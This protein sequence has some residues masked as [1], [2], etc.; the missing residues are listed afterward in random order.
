M[1]VC[2]SSCLC[3]PACNARTPYNTAL[4]GLSG[5]IAFFPRYLI[6]G[7]IFGKKK[8]LN[9]NACFYSVLKLSSETF[10]ILRRIQ[11]DIV[12]NVAYIGLYVKYQLFMSDIN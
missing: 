12:I 10:F 6:N 2:L 7:T 8:L 11:R 4:C 1:S 5:S 9:E 3:Y